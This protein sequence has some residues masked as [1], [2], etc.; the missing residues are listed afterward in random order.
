MF[1]TQITT[2]C[3]QLESNHEDLD[4]TLLPSVGKESR[5]LTVSANLQ[6]ETIYT[7]Q[8]VVQIYIDVLLQAPSVHEQGTSTS[9]STGKN[10]GSGG[11]V[12]T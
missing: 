5:N 2:Q 9:K 4:L 1:L 3:H 7:S 8:P 11:S 10:P 6:T 12:Q